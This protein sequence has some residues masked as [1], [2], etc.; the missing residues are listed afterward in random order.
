MT[1]IEVVAGLV[2]LG[3]I[4]ASLA[5]ARGRFARQWSVADRKLNA[6]RALDA[7]V[8][9]WMNV[10]G[11]SVPLNRQG[12]VPDA[13]KLI[14]RTRVLSDPAATK[15]CAAIV[16]VDIFDRADAEREMATPIAS[17]DLLVHVAPRRPATRP[18]ASAEEP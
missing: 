16:R 10:P 5:I 13:A 14:W 9:D 11:S 6:V 15:L 4:L 17:V 18:T 12:A 1:L 3:T 2:I 8:A 7:L